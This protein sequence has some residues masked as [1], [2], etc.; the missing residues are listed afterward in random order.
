M[1]QGKSPEQSLQWLAHLL[2]NKLVHT[3]SIQ[4]RQAGMT[5][6]HDLIAAAR[7]LFQLQDSSIQ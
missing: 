6:R 1:K 5:E 2:T 4:I 3:P 7:E